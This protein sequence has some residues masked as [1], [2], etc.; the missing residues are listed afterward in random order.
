MPNR[1]PC[2]PCCS[3]A[4]EPGGPE[5][6]S[7]LASLH[8]MHD[9]GA[10]RWSRP[11]ASWPIQRWRRRSAARRQDRTDAG[12][13]RAARTSRKQ[14]RWRGRSWRNRAHSTSGPPVPALLMLARWPRGMRDTR[15][16]HSTWRG[17]GAVRTQASEPREVRR[18]LHP[19]LF[20]A[21]RLTDIHQDFSTTP[22]LSWIRSA[23]RTTPPVLSWT[24]SASADILRQRGPRLARGRIDDVRRRWA[25]PN[26]ALR[27]R[28]RDRHAAA[29][30]A[31]AVHPGGRRAAPRRPLDGRRLHWP[32]AGTSP[33]LLVR[34]RG[35]PEPR[36]RRV[37]IEGGE[38][39]PA[40]R[41]P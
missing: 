8:A 12:A 5:L 40:R 23:R 31:R 39:R 6:R 1:R 22:K 25:R 37:Q 16:R 11:R 32:S 13:D 28:Q 2:P 4:P 36:G 26:S 33:A 24:G 18:G 21:A 3:S 41:A 17:R 9:R 38:E 10:R 20:L 34:L 30:P 14:P 27:P 29:R 35:Q 15:A 7:A 19:G